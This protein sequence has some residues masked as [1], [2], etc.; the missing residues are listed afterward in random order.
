MEAKSQHQIWCSEILGETL[1]RDRTKSENLEKSVEFV[2][3]LVEG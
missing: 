3:R 1:G 2:D